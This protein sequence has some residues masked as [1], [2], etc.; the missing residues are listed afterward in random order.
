MPI[1]DHHKALLDLI[2]AARVTLSCFPDCL[3]N[4]DHAACARNLA[5]TSDFLQVAT[6]ELKKITEG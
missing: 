2:E 3:A 5:L 6:I 1:P 4:G